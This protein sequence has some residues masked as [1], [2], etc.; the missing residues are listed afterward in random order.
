ML[1]LLFGG[2]ERW[3]YRYHSNRL[4]R[5]STHSKTKTSLYSRLTRSYSRRYGYLSRLVGL[6]SSFCSRRKPRERVRWLSSFFFFFFFDLLKIFI[7]LGGGDAATLTITQTTGSQL[8][9][10]ARQ[11][12]WFVLFIF[13]ALAFRSS[14]DI[15]TPILF[16]DFDMGVMGRS[17]FFSPIELGSCHRD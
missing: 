12:G 5:F 6:F 8:D 9:A 17:F 3:Y 14:L 7:Y 1:F 15:Y 4:L 11:P 10:L 2:K 16:F 13:L